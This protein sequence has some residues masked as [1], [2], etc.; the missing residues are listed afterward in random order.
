MLLL[1][2]APFRWWISGGHAL[3][4]H[5]GHAWRSHSDMDVGVVRAEVRLVADW[6]S[7]WSLAVA[8]GGEL[9]RWNGLPLAAGENNLWAGRS[10]AWSIDFTVGD[11]NDEEWI[12]RRDRSIRR[13]WPNAVRTTEGGVPYLAPELQLLFKSKDPRPTDHEDARMVI[14]LLAPGE[15]AFLLR[16]LSDGHEWRGV[17]G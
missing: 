1:D 2:G 12:Y 8:A 13:P 11:G 4:L 14:P 17:L 6:L 10:V 5:V 3:E 16:H 15:R 7:G 9:S